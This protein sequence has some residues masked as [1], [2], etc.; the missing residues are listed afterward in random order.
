MNVLVSEHVYLNDSSAHLTYE[1]EMG[2][3]QAMR[4][5]RLAKGK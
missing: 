1:N 2:K 4:I 5:L 3:V